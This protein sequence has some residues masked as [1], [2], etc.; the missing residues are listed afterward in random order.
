[1][2]K[3]TSL[4]D[5]LR[6]SRTGAVKLSFNEVETIL[7]FRLPNS[8]YLYPAW[9]SNNP[10]G[11][12]HCLAWVKEGWQSEQVDL[13]RREVTFRRAALASPKVP[14]SSGPNQPL[15]GAL[16]GTVRFAD[17]FDLAEPTGEIWAADLGHPE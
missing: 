15:Y 5:F 9:W 8:A 1:M 16:K 14:P 2:S 10:E 4:R 12:S 6:G 17:D 11:H 13:S 7:G 3:Y